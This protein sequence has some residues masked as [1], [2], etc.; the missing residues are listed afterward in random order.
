MQP[1]SAPAH[2]L[3]ASGHTSEAL[4]TRIATLDW[5]RVEENLN[6]HGY[7]TTGPLLSPQEC[8]A[9]SVGYAQ[10]DQFRSRVVMARYGFGRGEYRYYAYPLPEPIATLRHAL[11]PP[12]A[13][14][15]NRWETA[16]GRAGNYPLAHTDYLAGCH[17]VGQNR[18]TPLLLKYVEGDYNCLHQDIYGELLFPLQATLLLSAP[19]EEFSGGEFVMTEQRPRKQS[20]VEVVPLAQGE[21]V[22]FAVNQRPVNGLRGVSRVTLRHGVSRLHS[23]Q[24][25]ALGVIFHDA[26]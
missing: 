17:A 19:R 11:Y 25:F 2:N 10:P 9:L 1:P 18:P 3:A 20:R 14:I 7:A 26:K 13:G 5:A 21:A 23:G 15:A 6:A 4:A 22:I 8:H 16:L 12:L 24:R